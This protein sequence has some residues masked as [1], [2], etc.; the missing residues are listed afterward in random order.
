MIRILEVLGLVAVIIL[1]FSSLA[2]CICAAYVCA[3]V[4]E[5]EESN[6]KSP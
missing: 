5:D 2:A 6:P 4:R 3:C 1:F